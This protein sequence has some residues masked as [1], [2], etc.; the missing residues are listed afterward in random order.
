MAARSRLPLYLGLGAAGAGGYYLY[1]AGGSPRVASKEFQH[2]V[3]KVLPGSQKETQKQGEE[4]AAK[5][6]VK[7]DS[8]VEEA[9]HNINEADAVI[10][11]KVSE[12]EAKAI[13]L[14]NESI[15][16]LKEAKADT[17]KELHDTVATFDKTVER[18][19]VEAKKGIASWLG[20]GGSK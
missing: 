9:K 5:A 18:K 3:A 10:S 20:F 8:V 7:L 16:K 13:Q 17:Q 4:W 14:K 6:G 19:T 2:D 1:T 12:A 11:A 15:A